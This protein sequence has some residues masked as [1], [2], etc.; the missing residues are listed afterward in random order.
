[1]E[2]EKKT[3]KSKKRISVAS[4]LLSKKYVISTLTLT[5]I[6]SEKTLPVGGQRRRVKY[7]ELPQIFTVL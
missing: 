5:H 1:L 6:T 4:W 3:P 7:K 2:G